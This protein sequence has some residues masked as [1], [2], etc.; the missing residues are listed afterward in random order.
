MLKFVKEKR[1][2]GCPIFRE[3]IRFKALEEA[4]N[5]N[6]PRKNFK[7]SMGWCRRMMKR[8]GLSLRRRTTLAQKL[9]GDF[10][11]KLLV[12]QRHVISLRKK[13]N[14]SLG[15]MGNADQTPVYFDIPSNLTVN[16]KGVLLKPAGYEKS[17][18]TVMLAVTADGQKLRPYDISKRKTMPKEKLCPGVVFRVQEKGWMTEELVLD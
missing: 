4:A 3:V 10:N 13:H 2:E 18:I 16:K 9:P 1:N 7:A 14:Y 6:I 15:N 12:Y 5:L 17:R 8:N 11:E